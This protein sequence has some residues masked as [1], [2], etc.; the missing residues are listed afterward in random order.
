M[1]VTGVSQYNPNIRVK[2]RTY[3]FL[4]NIFCHSN[5]SHAYDQSKQN[6]IKIKFILWCENQ[7]II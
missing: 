2:F 5:V 6:C 7:K 3:K 4:H 1:G